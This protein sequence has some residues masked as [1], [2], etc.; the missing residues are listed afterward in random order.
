L[1]EDALSVELLLSAPVIVRDQRF[2]FGFIDGVEQL[3]QDIGD[4]I[5]F[6]R[7]RYGVPAS[8]SV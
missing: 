6:F 5:F 3:G 7:V 4:A 1:Q 2:H 8:P